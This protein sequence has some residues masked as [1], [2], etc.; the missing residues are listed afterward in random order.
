[1]FRFLPLAFQD[2][3]N[4]LAREKMHNAS[5]MAGLAFN[6][7]G[8]GLNLSLIHIL[9]HSQKGGSLHE[10]LRYRRYPLEF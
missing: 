5:C 9:W 3:T 4:L 7:A 1:M 2:G 10:D 6:S 8:L